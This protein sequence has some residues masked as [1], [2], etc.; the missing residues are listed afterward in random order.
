MRFRHSRSRTLDSDGEN[1][2]PL[3]LSKSDGL[4]PDG[5]DGREN[6]TET[7]HSLS[8]ELCRCTENGGKQAGGR[9]HSI[10]AKYSLSFYARG[11]GIR[12]NN[13]IGAKSVWKRDRAQ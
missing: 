1:S 6:S 9:E 12:N 10:M 4:S 2:S 13:D 5:T 11:Q 3:L 7:E 8:L